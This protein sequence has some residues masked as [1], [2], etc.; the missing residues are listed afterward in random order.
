MGRGLIQGGR[1]GLLSPSPGRQRIV[2][3]ALNGVRP[4]V[5]GQRQSGILR[6]LHVEQKLAPYAQAHAAPCHGWQI[7]AQRDFC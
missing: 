7:S 6:R 1:L 2:R 5:Q 3:G 4:V